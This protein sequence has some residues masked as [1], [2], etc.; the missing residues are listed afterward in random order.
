MRRVT[1]F[2]SKPAATAAWRTLDRALRFA[3]VIF[4]FGHRGRRVALLASATWPK[5]FFSSLPHPF[6]VT[7]ALLRARP[8]RSIL[9]TFEP[10]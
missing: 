4:S 3:G 1:R 2:G 7:V 5:G 9:A 6:D 10:R 8:D